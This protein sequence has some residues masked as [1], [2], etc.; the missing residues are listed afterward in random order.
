MRALVALLFLLAAGGAWTQDTVSSG[1]HFDAD[2]VFRALQNAYPDWVSVKQ[3]PGEAILSVGGQNFVWAQGRLLPPDRADHWAEFEPQPFYEY[4]ATVPDVASWSDDRIA[5]AETRIAGRR[6]TP[7]R[8][9]ST[10]YDALW[11]I[12]D[13]GSADDSQKRIRFLGLR[14]TVHQSLSGPLTR[15]E[16]RLRAARAGDPSLDAFLSSLKGLDGYNWRSIA[17]T[18]SRS[19]HA[20]GAAIDLD[21]GSYKGKTPYWLWAAQDQGAWYRTAWARRWEPHPAVVA[22]F[23]AEGFVWGGKWLL[24]DTIHFE[25][26]PE[27]L[28]LSKLR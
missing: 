15:I 9:D 2:E 4:P 14:V 8:R 6:N 23:E 3:G 19:N 7:L 28:V 18:Q 21:P 13:R 10:F 5:E 11:G 16:A 24:F 26:R 20:Y 27:I 12:H 1:R 25:Y 22:A 17:E